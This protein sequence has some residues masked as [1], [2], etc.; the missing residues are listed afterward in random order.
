MWVRMVRTEKFHNMKATLVYIEV[1]ISLF[2]VGR[3]GFPNY[4]I[5]IQGFCCLPSLKPN[6]TAMYFRLQKE[7]LQAVAVGFLVDIQNHTADRVAF[8]QN[9]VAF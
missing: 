9:Q 5:R 2:K 4:R 1:D 3:V 7:Q 6:S 8:L